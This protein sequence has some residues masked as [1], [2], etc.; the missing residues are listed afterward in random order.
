MFVTKLYFTTKSTFTDY[1][2]KKNIS[3][4]N[5]IKNFRKLYD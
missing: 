2:T 1:R 5:T 4:L 3:R